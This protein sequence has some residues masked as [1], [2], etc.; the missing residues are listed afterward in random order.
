MHPKFQTKLMKDVCKRAEA[1][2]AP[3]RQSSC[4]NKIVAIKK[5]TSVKSEIKVNSQALLLDLQARKM[6]SSTLKVYI[7]KKICYYFISM[8][9]FVEK[10]EPINIKGGQQINQIHNN[11][12]RPANLKNI[13]MY[14][15]EN[16]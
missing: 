12:P 1:M 8:C 3:F 11:V 15:Q 5:K 16:K 2:R 13:I 14:K 4:T 6:S 10:K 9:I 7:T